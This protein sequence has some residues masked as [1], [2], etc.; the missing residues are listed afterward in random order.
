MTLDF[1]AWDEQH[2]RL[3]DRHLAALGELDDNAVLSMTT[4]T[5]DR[6]G[7]LVWDG[8]VGTA[9]VRDAEQAWARIERNSR[10]D[11]A[12]YFGIGVRRGGTRGQ[13]GKNDVLA[14]T[15]LAADLDWAEG[16]HK[17]STNPPR[18][19]LEQWINDCPA[20]PGLI[21][22]SGGGFHIYAT[23]SE[24]VDVQHDPRG[25]ALYA[26]WR[27]WWVARA[28]ED[29]FNIDLAPLNNQALV[30][31]VAG[32]PCPKYPGALVTIERSLETT[33]DDY[34]IDD[35]LT[36]FPAPPEPEKRARTAEGRTSRGGD[37]SA[38]PAGGSLDDFTPG[39]LFAVE[40]D[41]ETILIDLLDADYAG[42]TG[43]AGSL[44]LPWTNGGAVDPQHPFGKNGG[45][46]VHH[47]GT[48]LLS[49]YGQGVREDWAHFAG[50]IPD[51]H[52]ELDLYNAF[53]ALAQVVAR[54]GADPEESWSLAARL[55]V[56]Y[57]R[58]DKNGFADYGDL[59]DDLA[60][61]ADLDDLIALVPARKP[62]PGTVRTLDAPTRP[63]PPAAVIRRISGDT[64]ALASA[65]KIR[66][67]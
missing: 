40:G 30:L 58:I 25:R 54:K 16:D 12:C 44:L 59:Y 39:D 17:S 27:H 15:L 21:V 38:V 4:N 67:L 64:H 20:I 42:R 10:K 2:T 47:D 61:C 49:I 53:Y 46:F 48:P 18:E 11:A 28:R 34:E 52:A 43:D 14:H 24:P 57:R 23:L 60:A 51:T 66:R 13:G 37:K 29:G 45:V 19:V 26:G 36:L 6:E 32:T 7:R 33:D 8:F 50:T 1:D 62:R 3:F 41:L 5:P 56:R 31:R 63:A 9:P 35:L 55:V 65:P 22:N